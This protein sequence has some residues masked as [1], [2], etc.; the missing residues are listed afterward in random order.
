M[1]YTVYND[2]RINKHIAKDLETIKN[3]LLNKIKSIEALILAGGFGR[4]QGGVLLEED[5][6]QPINDY[7]IYIVTNTKIDKAYI[8][9]LRI[10]LL[11][12]IK[13]RQID[14]EVKSKKELIRS[15][16]TV[17]NYDLK[18][19]S[20]VF[21]GDKNVLELLPS[22]QNTD[23]KLREALTPVNLY[24]ISIIQ[25]FPLDESSET[26]FWCQQQISKS[27]LGWSMALTIINQEYQSDYLIRG[28]ILKKLNL[29]KKAMELINYAVEFKTRP[30]LNTKI[31]IKALWY[32]NLEIHL[33]TLRLVYSKF[34]HKNVR[35]VKDIIRC[36]KSDKRLRLKKIFGAIT[37]N[38]QYKFLENL[39]IVE[40]LILHLIAST[41]KDS[42]ESVW[43]EE[44]LKIY[45]N[46]KE[47]NVR[48]I[49]EYCINNDPNCS[50]WHSRGSKIIY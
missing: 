12:K 16:K 40:I 17:A 43:I 7:D 34:Y 50:L 29:S 3:L 19:A 2:D 11:N 49:L 13:I 31:K 32:E 23:I 22:Y 1:N 38:P 45:L 47:V 26:N 8:Q 14:L 44:Q 10:E 4:S 5:K 28:R 18:Y 42:K 6:I 30:T 35:S 9:K 37:F 48:D 41:K 27:I 15:K 39:L 33:E 25:S 24:L 21:Y 20:Y 36:L 46:L